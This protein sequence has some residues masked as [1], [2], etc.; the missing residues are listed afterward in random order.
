M[1][2]LVARMEFLTGFLLHQAA[3]YYLPAAFSLW[4]LSM[5]SVFGHYCLG[6]S[7]FLPT[8]GSSEFFPHD[9]TACGEYSWDSESVFSTLA[10]FSGC[11]E[12][13]LLESTSSALWDFTLPGRST[14]EAK[15]MAFE[16][17]RRRR[18]FHSP[19]R[20]SSFSWIEKIPREKERK[21]ISALVKPSEQINWEENQPVLSASTI[22]QTGV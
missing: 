4:T 15:R 14:Q 7:S 20:N 10:L 19:N 16:P 22:L 17:L 5:C 3:L 2:Y 1:V 21:C 8:E 12:A 6:V 11:S 9:V 13:F 18:E